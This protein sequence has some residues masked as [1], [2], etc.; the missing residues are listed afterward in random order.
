MAPI[1]LGRYFTHCHFL[2]DALAG[3]AGFVEAVTFVAADYAAAATFAGV[4]TLV[5]A[6]YA[7]AAT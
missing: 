6:D 1:C 7:A 4:A 3:A 2:D 5:A